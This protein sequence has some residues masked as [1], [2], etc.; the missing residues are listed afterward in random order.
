MTGSNARPARSIWLRTRRNGERQTVPAPLPAIGEGL[1]ERLYET[2][3][4]AADRPGFQARSPI[5]RTGLQRIEL[6][7]LIGHLHA[8]LTRLGNRVGDGDFTRHV[9]R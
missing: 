3:A 1:C 4:Q 7:S 9:V 2:Q 8:Q 6:D 5:R